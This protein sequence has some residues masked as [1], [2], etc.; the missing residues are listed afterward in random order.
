VNFYS[1]ISTKNFVSITNK[2]FKALLILEV[3]P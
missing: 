1:I 2:Q 3:N